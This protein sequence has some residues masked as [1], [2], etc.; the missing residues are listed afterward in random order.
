MHP[1]LKSSLLA[2]GIALILSCGHQEP[3]ATGRHIEI[4]DPAALQ[5]LDTTRSIDII[6]DG[7][8]WAEGPLYFPD[9][10][11]LLLSDIPN[12]RIVN[13]KANGDT[14]TYLQPSG[15]TGSHYRGKEPGSNGLLLNAKGQLVLMQHGDR[16]IAIMDAPL[17]Q[18]APRFITLVDNYEGKRLNSPNDGVFTKDGRLYFTDP[19]Y[20][21][22]DNVNDTA[23]QLDFQGVFLLRPDGQLNLLTKDLKFPNGIALS[24]DERV[25]YVANSD[26]LNK[27]WMKYELDSNG[28]IKNQQ[29]FYHAAEDDGKPNGN[30]DGM[31]VHSNGW[32][33]ASGPSGI[34]VFN[35]DGKLLAK[36]VTGV[37]T[38]NC[39]FGKDEKELFMTCGSQLMRLKLKGI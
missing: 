33:F 24:P 17:N 29:V 11:N 2:A 34:W 18:P 6:A 35:P 10:G 20:G 27:M 26:S 1:F 21:L 12:N 16:R 5:V 36:I 38:S 3:K 8:L 37:R 31:K 13:L 32:V 23:K 39:R 22:A 15:F 4:Y 7:F 25:L 19:P 14:S 28:L 9:S 30:P